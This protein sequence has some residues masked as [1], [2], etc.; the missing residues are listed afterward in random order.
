MNFL[1][2]GSMEIVVVLLVAFIVLGPKRM[3]KAAR[4]L[5]KATREVGRMAESL[6]KMML[7]EED[8]SQISEWHRTVA[9]PSSIKADPNAAKAPANEPVA[10]RSGAETK[11]PAGPN[12]GSDGDGPGPE[13]QP[14]QHEHAEGPVAFKRVAESERSVTPNEQSGSDGS[15]SGASTERNT[16]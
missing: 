3:T 9:G 5:G 10:F 15:E 4:M 8:T 13:A 2:M 14:E 11:L 7:D 16:K 6:P 12:L 1:G